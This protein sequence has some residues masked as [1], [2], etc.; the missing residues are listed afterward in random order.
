M[1][2][3]KL[4]AEARPV[5][6]DRRGSAL[7][8]VARVP[9]LRLPAGRREDDVEVA[10]PRPQLRI[11]SL[12]LTTELALASTRGTIAD[13]G[14]YLVVDDARRSRL[15][16][17]Q[18]AR[19][20]G[21]AAGR[22]G[23][24]LDA[25]LRSRAARHGARDAVVGRHVRAMPVRSTSSSPPGFTIERAV[26]M[27]A[28]C[29]RARREPDVLV[30]ELRADT[31][32]PSSSRGRSPTATTSSTADSC[33]AAPRGSA[34]SSSAG[35]AKFWGAFDGD[36]L[37][38]E[39]RARRAR[40]P[41]PLSGRPDAA[42]V[43]RARASRARCCH[44]AARAATRRARRSSLAG[45]PG[46]LRARGLPHRSS[47]RC[48]RAATRGSVSDLRDHDRDQQRAADDREEQHRELPR[49]ERPRGLRGRVRPSRSADT[50]RR[51]ATSMF[52][53]CCAVL[54]RSGV[55]IARWRAGIVLG[56][57]SDENGRPPPAITG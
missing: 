31:R 13:R 23:R 7:G 3:C 12:A 27:T 52:I 2:S 32:S 9:R 30:R 41:G 49:R 43:S 21:G 42:G 53:A 6:S 38:V 47:A 48:R 46:S 40:R 26:V 55:C 22:R 33:S 29:D 39:P 28:E 5:S 20:A 35:I 25:A 54:P 45:A 50:D 10:R 15:L 4:P 8:H 36:A 19:V 37:V 14:D 56:A 57:R 44:A 51:P 16:P 34:R 17:R 18:P 1:Y 11:R 24:V